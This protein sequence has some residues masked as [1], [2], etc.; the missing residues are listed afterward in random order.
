MTNPE[1]LKRLVQLPPLEL[2][3]K[4]FV[5]KILENPREF[6]N[7]LILKTDRVE[8]DILHMGTSKSLL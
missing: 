2:K 4:M 7:N 3:R 1:M 5:Q 6:L 8:L